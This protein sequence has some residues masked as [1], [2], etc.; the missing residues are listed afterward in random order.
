MIFKDL[1]GREIKIGNTVLNVWANT[2]DYNQR[3]DGEPGIIQYRV[4]KV[5]KF[6][7]KSI[8]IQYTQKTILKEVCIFNT[9][10]RIII[11][12]D[13][14]MI[15]PNI[16]REKEIKEKEIKELKRDLLFAQQGL[17]R[18]N[19]KISNRDIK[20]REFRSV[21]DELESHYTRF[22]ILDL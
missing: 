13:K 20:I 8:R 4:A 11:M 6:C 22:N 12:A 19:S 10:N 21:I 3:G 7:P 2:N 18:A 16:E 9:C 14:K 17:N 15:D 5:I 1:F